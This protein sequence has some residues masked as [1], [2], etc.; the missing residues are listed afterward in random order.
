MASQSDGGEMSLTAWQA[1]DLR[2]LGF[3]DL[4]EEMR[5]NVADKTGDPG[6]LSGIDDLTASFAGELGVYAKNLTTGEEIAYRADE[7]M[8]TASTI[9]VAIMAEL[10]RQVGSGQVDLEQRVR[11]EPSD[12]Y[13]GTGV[14][15]EL[16]PG[17][18]PTVDDLCR[19]MIIQSDNVA[20]GMLV[21]RLGKDRINQSLRDWGF[22]VTE[23]RWNLALGGDIRQYAV[24]TP[25]ELGRLM[26]LI[27]T[28][29]FLTPEACAEM[30]THLAKQQHLE[31]IPRELPY[32][33][34]ATDVGNDQGVHVMNKIGNYMGMRADV[35]IVTAPAVSFVL[36]TANEGSPDHGFSVDQEGNVLN[37]RVAKLVFDAWV[38][39]LEE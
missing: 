14:L 15:K 10:Y 38:G 28:D 31:Q 17:L 36:A 21:R 27:A 5:G 35:A 1:V 34:Y 9:K 20:T 37:G 18:E 3:R 19:L 7:V 25:R 13:G 8:P 23:L 32:N 12:W 22:D 39:A 16:M 26:E 33:Q 30:R 11:M 2:L 24:S 29:G 6:L 4:A